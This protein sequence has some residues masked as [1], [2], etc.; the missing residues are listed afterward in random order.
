MSTFTFVTAGTPS[1]SAYSNST[2][3]GTPA[4]VSAGDFM[5][6]LLDRE[7]LTAEP[8]SV[9]TGWNPIAYKDASTNMR[10]TGIYYKIATSSEGATQDF[11][12]ASSDGTRSQILAWRGGFNR[13]DPIDTFSNTLYVSANSTL[14]AASATAAADNSPA[15]FVGSIYYSPSGV[16]FT[17]PS[18]FTERSDDGDTDSDFY[19]T[20][21]DAVVSQGATGNKDATMTA[22]TTA[23]KHAFLLILNPPVASNDSLLLGG[24]L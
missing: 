23:G 9:P 6:A 12:W 19:M 13:L 24:G 14:R 2:T 18:G 10:Y 22:S 1:Y 8:N 3:P 15:I 4:G 7:D 11:G 5:L 21:A 20:F 16:T 17:P